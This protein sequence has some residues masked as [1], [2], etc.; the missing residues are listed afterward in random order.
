MKI[1]QLK[2]CSG[3][4]AC[5]NA[6]PKNCITMNDDSEGF[7]YPEVTKDICINCGLC[8]K[9]CP[10]L[11]KYEGNPKGRAYAAINNDEDVRLKSSSGGIFTLIA[12]EVI[13][14]GGAVFGAA[15]DGDFK[16]KHILVETIGDLEK[17]RGSKYVQSKIGDAYKLAK[18]L[19]EGGR[20]VLFSGTP[21]QISGLKSYLGKPY[22]NLILQD[23]ICHGAPSPK[24]WDRYIKFREEKASATTQNVSFR[25]KQYGWKKFSMLFDFKDSTRHLKTLAEDSYMKAFLS[26]L[27]LRPSCYDCHS[28]SAERE[29]DIT[30]A[31]FWGVENVAPDMFDNKG[32]S[33]VLVNSSKGE[34]LFDAIKD[35][36]TAKEVD[37][38]EAIKY[39]SATTKSV[40]KPKNR[41]KFMKEIMENDFEKTVEKYTKVGFVA[42]NLRRV[43]RIVK[44]IIK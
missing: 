29:S 15:F 9:V 7:W 12:Q 13:A 41:D 44:K 20:L 18:K 32:T 6:C 39:N 42:K 27:S 3:C 28:K 19:L 14:R 34:K 31:D 8:E 4:S 26:D 43:K 22:E 10:V 38:D 37:F 2:N 1:D 16:V 36:V 30:L 5:F 33:L 40:A 17:L 11:K 24:V 23:I 35:L 21:C 25:N